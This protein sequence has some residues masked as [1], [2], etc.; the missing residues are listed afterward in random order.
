ML[1][2]SDEGEPILEEDDVMADL[3]AQ[4]TNDEIIKS[5][6]LESRASS[7]GHKMDMDIKWCEGNFW[8]LKNY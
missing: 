4:M 7:S 6:S 1:S 2:Q 3:P 8:I 5:E